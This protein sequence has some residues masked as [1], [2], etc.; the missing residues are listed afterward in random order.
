MN[1]ILEPEKL[2]SLPIQML[3]SSGNTLTEAP[4]RVLPTIWASLSLVTLARQLAVTKGRPVMARQ[5]AG[6]SL[7]GS[8]SHICLLPPKGAVLGAADGNRTAFSVE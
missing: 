3:I 8:C 2:L 4:R 7:N 1:G 6:A 5:G